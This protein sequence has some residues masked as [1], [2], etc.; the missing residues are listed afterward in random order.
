MAAFSPRLFGVPSSSRE[1]LIAL[2]V[3]PALYPPHHL[4]HRTHSVKVVEE[5]HK[6]V[7]GCACRAE[8]STHSSSVSVHTHPHAQTHTRAR[9]HAYCSLAQRAVLAWKAGPSYQ[10]MIYHNK[11][12]FNLMTRERTLLTL[13]HC[14]PAQNPLHCFIPSTQS[15]FKELNYFSLSSSLLL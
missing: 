7:C 11:V 5:Q 14:L 12:I 8:H 15:C 13:A 1:S 3:S 4:K 10:N 2:M 6:G 9:T